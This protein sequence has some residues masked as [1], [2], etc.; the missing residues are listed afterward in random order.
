MLPLSRHR[1]GRFSEVKSAIHTGEGLT[2]AVKVVA[3][4]SLGDEENLEALETE[5]EILRELQHPHIVDLKEVVVAPDETYIV[6]E[7]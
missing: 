4:E 5:I 7:L 3:N 2:Y 6:M 1:S